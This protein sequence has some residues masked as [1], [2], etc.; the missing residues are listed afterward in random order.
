MAAT[1]GIWFDVNWILFILGIIGSAV[2]GV[3]AAITAARTQDRERKK[4]LRVLCALGFYV[5]VVLGLVVGRLVSGRW[6]HLLW[7]PAWGAITWLYFH[8]KKHGMRWGK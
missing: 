8:H 7:L 2:M 3:G 6:V 1:I 4:H 5:S